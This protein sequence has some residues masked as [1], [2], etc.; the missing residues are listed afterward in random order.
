METVRNSSAEDS[1]VSVLNAYSRDRRIKHVRYINLYVNLVRYKTR[2]TSPI[3]GLI[4]DRFHLRLNF[5]PSV[6]YVVLIIFCYLDCER[7]AVISINFLKEVFSFRL[8]LLLFL[9]FL[10]LRH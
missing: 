8:L 7:E 10:K 4:R 1:S 2:H 9:N 3:R 6:S 5:K